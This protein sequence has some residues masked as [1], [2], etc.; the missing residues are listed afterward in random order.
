MRI[1]NCHTHTFTIDHVPH[2]FIKI[3]NIGLVNLFSGPVFRKPLKWLLRNILPFTDRDLLDRYANFVELTANKTQEDTFT[4]IREYYPAGTKFIV[5]S[6]DMKY[7]AAGKPKCDLRE[8]LDDLNKLYQ[9]FPDLIFPFVA[10]DP[11][12]K[13]A[14]SI[15]KKYVKEHKFRGIKLYPRL[16]FY[17]TD[18]RLWPIYEFAQEENIPILTH[19]SRG[20]V[21]TRAQDLPCTLWWKSGVG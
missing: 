9:K 6:M 16:G 15:L 5:L 3:G 7:M 19:C 13:N 18:K 14:L 11:R 10:V 17:P 4:R 8:Q 1:I 20:G 21:Y 12:R 2:K